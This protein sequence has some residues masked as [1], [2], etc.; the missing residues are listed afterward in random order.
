[1]RGAA[2]S[3]H[4][5]TVQDYKLIQS[6]VETL[7]TNINQLK[8]QKL[9]DLEAQLE[10]VGCPRSIPLSALSCLGTRMLEEATAE[11]C[12]R[13]WQPRWWRKSW[14]TWSYSRLV[15]ATTAGAWSLTRVMG[16]G[17]CSISAQN[18]AGRPCQ[19]GSDGA[20]LP[21]GISHPLMTLQ[22]SVMDH[23]SSSTLN[24]TQ[25]LSNHGQP[26]LLPS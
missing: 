13:H 8:R 25:S 17:R 5:G 3:D 22:T 1:M 15:E 4:T 10:M 19:A 20:R 26:L 6:R 14:S 7:H 23:E 21:A 18:A 11:W 12:N 2:R 16:V 9:I 24:C